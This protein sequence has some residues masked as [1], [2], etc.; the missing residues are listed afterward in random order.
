M[1]PLAQERAK[2]NRDY[3]RDSDN[4]S[5]VRNPMMF[6]NM[7]GK[8][9]CKKFIKDNDIAIYVAGSRADHLVSRIKGMNKGDLSG[10][11]IPN[12]RVKKTQESRGSGRTRRKAADR[13][14]L[15]SGGE[16]YSKKPKTKLG[17]KRK[18]LTRRNSRIDRP[19]RPKKAVRIAENKQQ[20]PST[21]ALTTAKHVKEEGSLI[22]GKPE[23]SRVT[24][25][26]VSEERGARDAPARDRGRKGSKKELKIKKMTHFLSHENN[27]LPENLRLCE[28]PNPKSGKKKLSAETQDISKINP[29]AFKKTKNQEPTEAEGDER[30]EI[31]ADKEPI[32]NEAEISHDSE[33]DESFEYLEWSEDN[34]IK[35]TDLMGDSLPGEEF[36]NLSERLTQEELKILVD[37]SLSAK[38][39]QNDF[40]GI[41]LLMSSI[42]IQKR[43]EEDQ[44]RQNHVEEEESEIDGFFIVRSG[45]DVAVDKTS[46]LTVE[47]YQGILDKRES[48]ELFQQNIGLILPQVFYEGL[49]KE[50]RV[51][52]WRLL[53]GIKTEDKVLGLRFAGK[54]KTGLY[55]LDRMLSDESLETFREQKENN[56]INLKEL[57]SP[58]TEYKIGEGEPKLDKDIRQELATNKFDQQSEWH[59]ILYSNLRQIEKDLRRTMT[60]AVIARTSL[61]KEYTN[62]L[63]R[64]LLAHLIAE[65]EI[66]YVQSMTQLL[67]RILYSLVEIKL[68]E[69]ESADVDSESTTAGFIAELRTK[70]VLLG[71]IFSRLLHDYEL[72]F[73][74]YENMKGI[75][76][77]NEKLS[78]MIK[79]EDN[80]LF[81]HINQ[82]SVGIMHY[83]FSSF[84]TCMS[85]LSRLEFTPRLF[86]LLVLF[87][88][89]YQ[90]KVLLQL[91]LSNRREIMRQKDESAISNL[92]R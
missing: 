53:Y 27:T 77:M 23:S 62:T 51:G 72:R 57:Y 11:N 89:E 19:S 26:T 25:S 10:S 88:L 43:P 65:P 40:V 16:F 56:L 32:E 49:P 22:E 75:K 18:A 76:E 64:V 8:K 39:Q 60:P 5:L 87:G 59:T 42:K 45:L 63:R 83:F 73:F 55:L 91:L 6:E 33:L 54:I 13:I 24:N 47:E 30:V 2:I 31:T 78:S 21:K 86:D 1:N 48:M 50:V 15:Q 85:N 36:V 46:F 68:L 44:G 66:C 7:M 79:Q 92:I 80:D 69:L 81:E 29:N 84:Y 74:Y 35:D 28:K 37:M 61:A 12:Q 17:Q 38:F 70:E 20:Q 34:L 67:S 82:K 3:G 14:P 9:N 71:E 41:D 4:D 90:L 52:I 58:Y